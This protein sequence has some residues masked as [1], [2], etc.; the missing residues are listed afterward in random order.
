MPHS[1]LD[2]AA[3]KAERK[4]KRPPDYQKQLSESFNSLQM[5]IVGNVNARAYDGVSKFFF[6]DREQQFY[7]S[8]TVMKI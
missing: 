1:R 7:E 6:V 2:K 5:F 3:Q 8:D 4:E